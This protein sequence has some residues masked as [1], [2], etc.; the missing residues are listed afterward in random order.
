MSG[1][2]AR[3]YDSKDVVRAMLSPQ[4]IRIQALIAAVQMFGDTH[5]IDY[6]LDVAQAHFVPFITTGERQ[7]EED[8]P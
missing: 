6:V 5:D 7:R 8:Q 4:E 2:W 3:A 1:A